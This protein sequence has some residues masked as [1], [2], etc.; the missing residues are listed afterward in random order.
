[1]TVR[2]GRLY[3]II[4]DICAFANTNGGA[5]YIGLSSD[6]KKKIAGLTDPEQARE[7]LSREISNR[8]SPILTCTLDVQETSGKKVLRVLVPRG[9][10]PPYV[11]DDYKI[12]VRAE[13]ETGL[14]VRDEIVK[15]VVGGAREQTPPP[16][17]TGAPAA[18][19]AVPQDAPTA[20][21]DY[22]EV[23]P[24]TGVEIVSVVE[25]NGGR[26]YAL[27]DLRNGNVVNNVNS[28]ISPTPL[29]ICHHSICE[30]AA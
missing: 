17:P 21:E 15:L 7:Q 5:L 11:V 26:Y 1:M 16:V 18:P 20:E 3:T 22:L 6:P 19:G 4:A 2:G 23:S 30:A 29:G 9:D 27:R 12:Y 24:R 14:A 25:R 10:D 8:I 28:K 13:S